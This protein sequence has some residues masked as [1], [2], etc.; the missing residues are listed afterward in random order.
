MDDIKIQQLANEYAQKCDPLN[1]TLEKQADIRLGYIAGMNKA[2]SLFSVSGS[3]PYDIDL[4]THC[5]ARIEITNNEP[6]VIGAMNG[7]GDS[8]SFADI[9]VKKL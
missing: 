4:G 7:W 8:I 6:K 2:L 3:C 9:K 1:Q 5:R